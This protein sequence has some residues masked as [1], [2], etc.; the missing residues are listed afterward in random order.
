MTTPSAAEILAN[1]EKALAFL[2]TPSLTKAVGLYED[3][4]R[5]ACFC[6]LGAMFRAVVSTG[7]WVTY[8]A[9]AV[10]I[11]LP[12]TSDDTLGANHPYELIT[13]KNDNTP[14]TL[15]EMADFLETEIFPKFPI[16]TE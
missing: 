4:S 5:E 8:D 3:P 2:R 6:T 15:P 11:G 9:L 7:S 16:T 14:V 10:R 12:V 13:E 1:R